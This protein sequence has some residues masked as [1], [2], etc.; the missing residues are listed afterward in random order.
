M[1]INRMNTEGS[2]AV[3]VMLFGLEA[4]MISYKAWLR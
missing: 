2:W 1:Q 4:F 3:R